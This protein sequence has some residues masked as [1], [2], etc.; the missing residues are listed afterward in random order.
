MAFPLRLVSI[1]A[2][3]ADA[4]AGMGIPMPGNGFNP[5][6]FPPSS[7]IFKFLLYLGRITIKVYIG[8]I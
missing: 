2:A 7:A 6:C 1:N 5:S 3:K 4:G 8:I